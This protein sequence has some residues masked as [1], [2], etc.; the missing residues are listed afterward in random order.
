MSGFEETKTGIMKLSA[1][2]S[3]QI[4][5]LF[6]DWPYTQSLDE[7]EG[8]Y[9]EQDDLIRLYLFADMARVVKLKNQCLDALKRASDRQNWV[10][11]HMMIFVWKSTLSGDGLRQYLLDS[12]AWEYEVSLFDQHPEDFTVRDLS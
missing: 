12:L 9:E 6:Y 11:A 7:D 3:V 2:T 1:D 10:P 5:Q 8:N 4:F